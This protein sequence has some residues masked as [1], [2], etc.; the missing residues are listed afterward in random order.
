MRHTY[1]DVGG[2]SNRRGGGYS[3]YSCQKILTEH[4]PATGDAHGCPYRHFSVE[5]LMAL[6]QDVGVKDQEVLKGVRE[7]VHKDKKKY[8]LACNRFV[9][10]PLPLSLSV[11]LSVHFEIRLLT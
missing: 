10:L 3:P 11:S 7:D 5:N 1:G 2:D 4:P 9:L 8:H 6:L